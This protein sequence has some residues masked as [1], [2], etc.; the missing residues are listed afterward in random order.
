V[1]VFL[2]WAQGVLSGDEPVIQQA[3]S[4]VKLHKGQLCIDRAA[5]RALGLFTEA[6]PVPMT[7]AAL[8]RSNAAAAAKAGFVARPPAPAGGKAR[9]KAE[10]HGEEAGPSE[11]APAAQRRPE[12]QQETKKAGGAGSK[13]TAAGSSKPAAEAAPAPV[14]ELGCARCRYRQCS[15]C[16]RRAA[17]KR[18]SK[19]RKA[20]QE[21]ERAARAVTRGGDAPVSGRK[22]IAMEEEARRMEKAAK[23]AGLTGRGGRGEFTKSRAVF[24]KIQAHRDGGSAAK[25]PDLP[26]GPPAAQLKL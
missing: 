4:A 2:D 10:Q 26:V 8:Q 14:V 5:L 15:D 13:R 9:A 11:A 20:G 1:E 25:A 17:K 16:R 18:S 3:S 23:K 6:W 22:S 19:K 21:E 7:P 12:A 24:S